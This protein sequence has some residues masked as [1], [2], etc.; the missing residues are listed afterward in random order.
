[1]NIIQ[2]DMKHSTYGDMP[3]SSI[4]NVIASSNWCKSSEAQSP[5]CLKHA[6]KRRPAI[7]SE[8]RYLNSSIKRPVE[9]KLVSDDQVLSLLTITVD[10][11][12]P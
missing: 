8:K 1:M 5:L 11:M 3:S 7:T 10:E 4:F 12:N 9:L 2:S 6:I